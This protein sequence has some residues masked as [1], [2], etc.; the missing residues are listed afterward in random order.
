MNVVIKEK[1]FEFE[2]QKGF[3][4]FA[5]EYT[6]APKNKDG[7]DSMS[8]LE[9]F[10]ADNKNMNSINL[11]DLGGKF[12]ISFDLNEDNLYGELGNVHSV[13]INDVLM[14]ELKYCSHE[15]MTI[16][17]EI[18]DVKDYEDFEKN[19]IEEIILKI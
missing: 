14:E 6:K 4:Y 5:Y 1:V 11:Y 16:T 8:Y 15:G 3:V 9:L 17:Y 13:C 19:I 7:I 10:M 18:T 2:S 12:Y